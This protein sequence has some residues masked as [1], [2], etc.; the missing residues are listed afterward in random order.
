MALTKPYAFLAGQ[1][2]PSP[3]PTPIPTN[4]WDGVLGTGFTGTR[5]WGTTVLSDGGLIVNGYNISNYKG[6][7]TGAE[8]LKLDASG[9]I[10]STYTARSFNSAGAYR[11]IELD[12]AIYTVGF[13]TDTT[14]NRFMKTD[15]TTGAINS[16]FSSN[17][18][19]NL[20]G[21]IRGITTDGTSIYI[22][23]AFSSP[24][25]RIAKYSK[26]GVRDTGWTANANGYVYAIEYDSF[27]DTLILGGEFTSVNGTSRNYIAKLNLDG[28]LNSWY[29]SVSGFT[30]TIIPKGDGDVFIGAVATQPK[31]VNS[32]G[33]TVSSFGTSTNW[34]DSAYYGGINSDGNYVSPLPYTTATFDATNVADKAYVIFDKNGFISAHG[35]IDSNA[36]HNAFSISVNDDWTVAAGTFTIIDSTAKGLVALFNPSGVL[37]S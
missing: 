10:D 12:G 36:N 19:N 5:V 23:G 15:L 33:T 22:A 28:T 37:Q 30:S 4:Q 34:S 24:Q 21:S 9:N 1:A 29:P 14:P 3:T 32:S 6:V 11:S 35:A 18:G 8:H 17:V 13:W 26:D 27:D 31:V 25:T 20:N 2:G 7:F 16:T